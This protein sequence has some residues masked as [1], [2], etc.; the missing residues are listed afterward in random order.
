MQLDKSMNWDM[1]GS[2]PLNV[3]LPEQKMEQRVQSRNVSYLKWE[4]SD[5][6]EQK[7]TK[8]LVIYS[9]E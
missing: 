8:G 6:A 2:L 9:L 4:K 5:G 3:L 7:I 1:S